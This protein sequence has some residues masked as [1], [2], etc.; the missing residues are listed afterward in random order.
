MI[1]FRIRCFAFIGDSQSVKTGLGQY[2]TEPE[3]LK[4][5][6]QEQQSD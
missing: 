5:G 3:L 4:L 2:L 6:L 1:S